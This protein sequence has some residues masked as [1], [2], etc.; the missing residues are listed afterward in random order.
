[1][2]DTQKSK[3]SWLVHT[4]AYRGT[5]PI[6]ERLPLGTYRRSMPKVLRGSQGGGRFLTGEVPLYVDMTRRV[7]G[8][9]PTLKQQS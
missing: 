3:A 1:M 8:I 2:L 7:R 9:Q 5:A 4:F 6:R